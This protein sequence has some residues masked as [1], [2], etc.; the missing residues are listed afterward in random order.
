MKN[1]NTQHHLQED[2]DSTPAPDSTPK[3]PEPQPT[4]QSKPEESVLPETKEEASF[5]NPTDEM[6]NFQKL[7]VKIQNLAI[8]GLAESSCRIWTLRH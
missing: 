2:R 7:V 1:G 6:L 4:P 8:F 5:I 3:P